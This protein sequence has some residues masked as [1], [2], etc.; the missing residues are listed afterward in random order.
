[1]ATRA[2]IDEFLAQDRLALVG[3][4]R[5]A[6]S[7]S[8]AVYRELVDHGYDITPVNRWADAIVGEPCVRTIADLPDGIGGVIVMVRSAQAAQVVQE[9]A[10]RG[11]TRVWLHKGVGASSVSDEAIALCRDRGIAVIDGACPLMFVPH[12]GL[13]HRI[14]R[15]ELHLTGRLPR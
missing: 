4:S 12:P 14:H 10:D 1:M 6:K 15:G 11:I 8:H 9:C 7:F 2:A 5:D 3:L 13:V